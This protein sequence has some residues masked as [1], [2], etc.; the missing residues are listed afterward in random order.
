MLY[1]AHQPLTV[2]LI[3]GR[4]AADQAG[5]D[6]AGATAA[7]AAMLFFDYIYIYI[8]YVIQLLRHFLF[9]FAV[10]FFSFLRS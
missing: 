1:V 10:L 5:R 8:Y 6:A 7:A 9:F 4:G 2:F 3:F